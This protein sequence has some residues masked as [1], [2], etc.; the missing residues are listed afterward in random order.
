MVATT[1]AV[2][3]PL[4]V[5][6]IVAGDG[7]V[8][9]WFWWSTAIGHVGAIVLFGRLWRRAEVL[10]DAELVELRYGGRPA[11]VLRSVQA[12]FYAVAINSIVLGW[13]LAAMR[14][15]SAAVLPWDPE[16]VVVGFVLFALLYS[17]LG[18]L[19]A[20]VL[21]DLVQFTFAMTGSVALAFLAVREVGGLGPL[22]DQIRSLPGGDDTLRMV[23]GAGSGS[24]VVTVFATY[25]LVQW[26]ARM[27]ADGGGYLAQ[28]MFAARDDRQA[29]TAAGWFVWLH[30]VVRPWPW[31]LVGL[32]AL[33]LFPPGSAEELASLPLLNEAGDV[34]REAAYPLLLVKLMP[35]GLL[36][37][38]VAALLAAFMSTVDTHIHW[39]TSYLVNDL[40]RQL[41]RPRAGQRE[42]MI[43]SWL[44]MAGMAALA[45]A[46]GQV[47]DRVED[48]WKFLA[49]AG[50]GMGTPAL[51]RW[52]WWRMTAWAELLGMLTGAVTAVITYTFAPDLIHAH[53]LWITA[54]ASVTVSALAVAFGPATAP[55]V[56]RTFVARVRPPGYWGP[57]ATGAPGLGLLL[58]AWA[59]GIVAVF[60]ALIGIGHLLLGAPT[61]GALLALLALTTWLLSRHLVRRADRLSGS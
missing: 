2:D 58:G 59:A 32:A 43:A 50:A 28:R 11:R 60:A 40:Y 15:V 48:A 35:V 39:G 4:V 46:V 61:S 7:I 17:A 25:V 41:I 31:I 27:A 13:G 51:L 23:P 30:Y 1:F 18:G 56:L 54:G 44:C 8:G 24:L 26:W 12:C 55:E 10:T 52:I 53:R 47:I 42:L 45:L 38:A 49:A 9:N 29:A 5:T 33:V 3:T 20:V 34:D 14:K 6:G 37:I 21:T 16:W 22:V 19:R 57:H 36:G